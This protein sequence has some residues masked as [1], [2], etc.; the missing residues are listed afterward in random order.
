MRLEREI[1]NDLMQ[2]IKFFV[3]LH[4]E[5]ICNISIFLLVRFLLFILQ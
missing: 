1:L 2:F 3:L 5:V 4:Q